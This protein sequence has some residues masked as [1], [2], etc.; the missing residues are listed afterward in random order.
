MMPRPR[1]VRI[2]VAAVE[3]H[4]LADADPEERSTR[5]DRFVDDR[6][7][8]AA[9]QRVE[10][11]AERSDT[12]QHDGSGVAHQAGVGS[13]AGVGADVLQ[14]LLRRA[15]VPDAVVEHGDQRFATQSSHRPTCHSTPFVDG[16]PSPSTRT[17]SRRQRA[18]PLNVASMM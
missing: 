7:E 12:G 10:T 15:E 11:G 16:T 8:P 6:F 5:Q 9:A 2:F 4:L 18:T 3:Q 14:R 13:E 1:A 17:A